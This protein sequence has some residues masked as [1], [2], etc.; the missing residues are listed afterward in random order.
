MLALLG[1]VA[2]LTLLVLGPA[3]IRTAMPFLG[4]TFGI[5]AGAW[6]VFRHGE[7]LTGVR[8]AME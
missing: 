4:D 2:V 5:C 8:A 1:A 3:L 6:D 7:I